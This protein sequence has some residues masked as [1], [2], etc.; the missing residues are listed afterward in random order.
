MHNFS[1]AIA[2]LGA[3]KI[4]TRVLTAAVLIPIVLVSLYLGGPVFLIFMAVYTLGAVVEFARLLRFSLPASWAAGAAMVLPYYANLYWQIIPWD[5][6]LILFLLIAA[7][8]LFVFNFTRCSFLQCAGLIFAGLFVPV[9]ASTLFTIRNMEQG[10]YLTLAVFILTWGTDSGAFFT[11]MAWGRKKLAPAISPN[12]SWAGAI[13]GLI[14]GVIIAVG[15][16]LL[17]NV[18]VWGMILWGCVTATAG[19]LGDLCESAIKR[20]AGV[21]DSGNLFPGHGGFLDRIDSLLFTAAV[22]Y[23]F[24]GMVL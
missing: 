11:G 18:N 8:V 19:Q 14:T 15:F 1:G 24:F 12:K 16:G 13:G 2:G 21:K 4:L 23:I 17:I 3:F 22:S 10:L 9:L 6:Y 7:A 5:I 20:Y